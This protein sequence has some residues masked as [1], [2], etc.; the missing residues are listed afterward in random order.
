MNNEQNNELLPLV[1]DEGIVIGQ[2]TRGECHSNPALLHPVVHLHV[3]NW[4]GQL[5]LQ[6]RSSSKDLFPGF[7]DTAVGGHVGIGETPGE[8]LMREAM[9]EL[10]IDASGST[11]AAKYVWKNEHETELTYSY[12]IVHEGAISFDKIEIDDGRFFSKK[13]IE[14]RKGHGILTP[15]FENELVLL[16]DIFEE[17]LH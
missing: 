3:F 17:L 10:G 5:F 2:A 9:E 14:E 13:E 15:N 11:F 12:Y 4:K 7:W 16:A 8:S 1:N 6:K